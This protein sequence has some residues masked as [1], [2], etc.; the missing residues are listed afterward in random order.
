MTSKT[1]Y[2]SRKWLNRKKDRT[3]FIMCVVD[4]DQWIRADGKE[5]APF[6]SGEI[7]IADCGKIINLDLFCGNKRD[8]NNSLAK[9]DTLINELENV[10]ETIE[11][12][13]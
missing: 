4:K 11:N 8:R 2:Q 7:K 5:E 6:I 1:L 12:N 10:R 9:L 3:A 13:S